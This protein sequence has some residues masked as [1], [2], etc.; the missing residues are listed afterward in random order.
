[1]IRINSPFGKT[2]SVAATFAIVMCSMPGM[3][4]AS[5]YKQAS[6]FVQTKLPKAKPHLRDSFLLSAK[7]LNARQGRS[8]ENPYAAGQQKFDVVYKGVDLMSG[9]Y[10]MSATDLSFENGYGIPVNM[11]RSYSANDGDEGPLGKGWTVS[12]DARSTA[13]GLA[14]SSGSSVRSV[15]NSFKER[16]STQLNDPN[17][18][19]ADGSNATQPIQAVLATDASGTEETIQRDAD[20]ILSTPPWDKNKVESEYETIIG[21]DG[22]NYQ[23]MTHN[24]VITP[25]GTVFV[26]DKQGSYTYGVKPYNDSSAVAEPSN[27]LKVT[28]ATDRQGNVTTY[29]YGTGTVSFSKVNGAVTEH[30]LTKIQMPNGHY[31]NL[32]WGTSSTANRIVEVNDYSA[33]NSSDPRRVYYTYSSGLLTSVT[34]AGGKVMTYGYGSPS[35]AE[36]L[37]P[38]ESTSGLLT[39]ITDCRGLTTTINYEVQYRPRYGYTPSVKRIDWPNVQ[40]TSYWTTVDTEQQKIAYSFLDFSGTSTDPTYT[41]FTNRGYII[42]PYGGS[43]LSVEEHY[44]LPDEDNYLAGLASKTVNYNPDTLDPILEINVNFDYEGNAY[45]APLATTYVFP[46][47]LS[48]TEVASTSNFIGKPLTRTVKDYSWAGS[49]ILQNTKT[50]SYAYWGPEKYYQ[51]K[52]ERDQGGRLSYSDY[53]DNTASAGRKGQTYRVYDQAR[54]GI[55]LNTGASIPSYASSGSEWRYQVEIPLGDVNKYSAQFDYDSKGRAT[56][57]WKIQSTTTTPWTYVQTKTTYGLDTAPIW[58]AATQ[59]VEDYGGINRT[60]QTTAYDSYGRAIQVKDASNKEFHTYYDKDGVISSIK[61]VDGSHNDDIVT[62]VYGSSGVSNGQVTSVT[63]NLSG[64]SRSIGYGSSGSATGLPISTSETNGSDSYSVGYVYNAAGDRDTVTYTT[65]SALGLSNTVKWKYSDYIWVGLPTKGARVFQRLTNL[66]SSTGYPNSEEFHYAYDFSGRIRQAAF[67]QTPASWTPGT[68]EFYYTDAHRASTRART[69]YDYDSGG[70][71]SG[72]YNWWDTYGSGTYSSSPIRANECTYET[73]SL[74]RGIKTQNKF[75][76]VSS[77]SWNLQRTE[78]YGYD[79]NL[80]YLTSANYGDGLSNAT[81]SWTYDAAGNRASDSTNSGTWTYDN[82]NRMTASPSTS[83]TNDILGNR[84]G[85]TVSS[86]VTTYSWDDLNRMTGYSLTNNS[87]TYAYRADGMR[88]SKS[89]TGSASTQS[90]T[91]YRYDG[92]I[93]VEDVDKNSSGTITAITRMAIG[94]RGIDAISCTTSSGTNVTYPLYDAHGSSIGMLSKAGS[95][96]AIADERSYDAWGQVRVGALNSDYKGRYC[97]NLGHRQDEESGLTYMASRYYDATCGRFVSEDLGI[98]GS[99]WY[100]YCK[101]RPIDNA[102]CNGNHC[103]NIVDTLMQAMKLM[104]GQYGYGVAEKVIELKKLANKMYGMANFL[105]S[106]GAD[107][108]EDAEAKDEASAVMG[109]GSTCQQ[110]IDD[111]ERGIGAM[112]FGSATA[113]LIAAKMIE[114][115]IVILQSGDYT[116]LDR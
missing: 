97:A 98:Q 82:L 65:Q 108:M 61:R 15:P 39:S 49:Y 83:Y 37:T 3:A 100:I 46:R 38:P 36:G 116:W 19:T 16:P 115:M 35:V 6:D 4:L 1:M 20:G 111:T 29:T 32:V 72:V 51:K 103:W 44:Q 43:G 96:W 68:G 24:K 62:Y 63:D 5:T 57:V 102:D 71:I 59:V 48:K 86:V 56:D 101:N 25:E 53:Y 87:N 21:G 105:K 10:T 45:F 66:D 73:S 107:L 90:S 22:T 93:G 106:R 64:V 33:D 17:A 88:V 76:N 74:N 92:Q 69:F 79:A 112:Q 41:N 34:S 58:G 12:V 85:K 27:I 67:A 110:Y 81:P 18:T 9:N 75:Y 42:M 91:L 80:D 94:A 95:S 40:H 2:V 55:Y 78:T 28:T 14:K 84:T 113:A 13:G 26:Y 7:T 30:P 99:N 89:S 54:A 52:A 60:T 114:I 50:V 77:G 31:I 8:G 104:E 11:T 109:E 47:I 70:R 23:V